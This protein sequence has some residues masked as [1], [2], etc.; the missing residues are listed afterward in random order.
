MK[1]DFLSY[2][3]WYLIPFV[4]L[5]TDKMHRWFDKS[6]SDTEEN[7]RIFQSFINCIIT[8]A[9]AFYLILKYSVV[10]YEFL[11]KIV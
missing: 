10:V 6:S 7:N 1:I 9:I 11:I 3:Y 2:K 8:Y 4:A 5:N